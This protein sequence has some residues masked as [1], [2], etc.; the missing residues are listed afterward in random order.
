MCVVLSCSFLGVR[1]LKVQIKRYKIIY[2]TF[3]K[4]V[5]ESL[6]IHESLAMYTSFLVHNNYGGI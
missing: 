3:Y 5:V 2:D 1:F 6:F 4:F